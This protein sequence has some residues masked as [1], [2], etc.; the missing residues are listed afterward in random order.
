[1]LHKEHCD[2]HVRKA[3]VRYQLGDLCLRGEIIII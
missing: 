3:R 1:M 2:T